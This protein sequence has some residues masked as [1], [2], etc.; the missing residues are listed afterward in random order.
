[1]N[2]SRS[3]KSTLLRLMNRQ[4]KPEKGEVWVAVRAAMRHVLEG[5][6]LADVAAGALPDD[7][8]SLLAEPGAWQ[9]R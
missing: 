5:V 1:M 9:R 6:T 3:G 2:S 4:E 8:T 7:V